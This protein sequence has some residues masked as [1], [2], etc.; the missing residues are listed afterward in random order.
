MCVS[1]YNLNAVSDLVE[2][3]SGI[4]NF[5]CFFGGYLTRVINP[6]L[7]IMLIFFMQIIAIS[8][9]CYVTAIYIFSSKNEKKVLLYMFMLFIV[10]FLIACI[11]YVMFNDTMFNSF[12]SIISLVGSNAYVVIP[13]IYLIVISILNR[14]KLVFKKRKN[15]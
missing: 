8:L 12:A 9:Y 14:D 5:N 10:S 13:F 7:S 2:C 6:N 4:F 15:E 11:H 3:P 1:F